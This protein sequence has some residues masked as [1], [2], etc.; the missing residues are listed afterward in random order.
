MDP[1]SA[2]QFLAIP[3]VASEMV[4][5]LRD[6]QPGGGERRDRAS[7]LAIFAGIGL[8]VP[9]A[10][11]FAH[12]RVWQ[13]PG[14]PFAWLAAGAGVMLFGIIFR[15]RA[16][17]WLGVYFRTRVTLLDEH[18]LVTEGPYARLRHPSYTGALLCCTGYGIAFGSFASALVL[19]I[20]PAIALAYRIRVE[21][22]ALKERFGPEWDEY[23]SRTSAL[24][25]GFW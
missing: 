11:R 7:R 25:S 3:W 19:T 21:E 13:F 1:T 17:R 14:S 12:L 10:I 18:K 6:R 5:L 20:L 16:V 8:A 24:I 2:T 22:Q 4:V 9:L 23:R 15:H